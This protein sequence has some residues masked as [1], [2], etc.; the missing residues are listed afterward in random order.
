MGGTG[1]GG[2]AGSIGSVVL[3][4]AGTALLS[5]GRSQLTKRPPV[6]QE[7]ADRDEDEEEDGADNVGGRASTRPTGGRRTPEI[8]VQDDE[9]PRLRASRQ[10][11]MSDG[12]ALYGPAR[13]GGRRAAS[14]RQERAVSGAG[15]GPDGHGAM[16]LRSLLVGST[17]AATGTN[18]ATGGISST[19]TASVVGTLTGDASTSSHAYHPQLRAAAGGAGGAGG[20]G[21]GG[22]GWG[23]ATGSRPLQPVAGIEGLESPAVM[24]GGW[25]RFG[26][27]RKSVRLS[28]DLRTG[29]SLTSSGGPPPPPTGVLTAVPEDA[30]RAVHASRSHG[31]SQSLQGQGAV[32]PSP[33]LSLA[34]MVGL[35]GLHAVRGSRDS[36]ERSTGSAA[37]CHMQR[38]IARTKSKSA[39]IKR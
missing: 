10:H 13:G 17:A 23:G 6:L 11:P 29:T 19:A 20:G 3:L 30:M 2:R 31:G 24:M 8:E 37:S 35:G 9:T 1:G 36:P 12:V 4:S 21:G 14:A 25:R 32:P 28:L 27:A 26:L 16:Q 38:L 39:L 22:G 15:A 5:S 18:T 34:R 7:L 33:V